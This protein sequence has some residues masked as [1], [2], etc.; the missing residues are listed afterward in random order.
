MSRPLVLRSCSDC[1][2]EYATTSGNRT[3]PR[4]L[5][6]RAKHP[7]GDCGEPCDKRAVRC[8]VCARKLQVGPKNP[9][10]NGGRSRRHAL[11]GYVRVKTVGHPRADRNGYVPEHTLVMEECLGRYLLPGENVHHRNGRRDDNRPENLELW[12][13]AQPAGQRASDLLAWARE[14]IATY[15]PIEAVLFPPMEDL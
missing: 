15:E 6:H 4:C 2:R 13:V 7:C 9:G 5:H 1:S 10:W 12:V 8:R 11:R 14:L 3:C